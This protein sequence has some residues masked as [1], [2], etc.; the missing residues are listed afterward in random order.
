MRQL[1][2]TSLKE[3]KCKFF[4][5]EQLDEEQLKSYGMVKQEDEFMNEANFYNEW[6]YGRAVIANKENTIVILV[7][8]EEHLE[9][10]FKMEDVDFTLFIQRYI[11]LMSKI[12]DASK[13]AFDTKIGYATALGLN[14]NYF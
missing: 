1:C 12:E 6:P 8:K 3:F 4:E 13:F 10:K 14:M 2:D 9:I 11:E 5:V 7:N